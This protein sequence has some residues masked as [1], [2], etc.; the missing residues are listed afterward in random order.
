MIK[1]S[2]KGFAETLLF[3]LNI[4]LLFL[5]LFGSNMVVPQW[6]Q[7]FGRLHPVILHFPIVILIMAML[8]EFFRFRPA[9][10]DEQLYQNFTTALLL[11]GTVLAAITAIMGLFLSREPGYSG[12]ILQWHKWMG[13]SVVFVSSVI[14]WCRNSAWY[15]ELVARGGALLICVCLIFAGH[16]GADITH[17]EDFILAPVMRHDVKVPIDQALVYRDVIQPIFESK[18]ISC[19]NDDKV[20]GGL[21]LTDEASILKGGKTGKLFIPGN[22]EVSL[23][24]QRIHLPDDDEK[25]MP[26]TGKTQLSPTEMKLLYQWI[27]SKPDFNKKVMS[28]PVTDSLRILASTLLTPAAATADKYDFKAADEKTIKGLNNNYRVVYA[29]ANGSPALAVNI[30]NK[31]IYTPKVL[32]ELSPIKKQ[33]IS[34]N[35]NKMPVKDEELKT[36]AGFENLRELNLNFTDITGSGLKYLTTLKYLKSL[37]L[38]G[39]NLNANDIKQVINI[40]SLT[41]LTVWDTGIK[42]DEIQQ[43]K[44]QNKNINFIEGFKDSGKSLKLNAPQFKSKPSVF[45]KPFELLITHPI[46]GVDIRYTTDGTDPDSIKSPFYKPGIIISNNTTIKARAYK[47]GWFGSDV[48]MASYAQSLYTP[49]SIHVVAAPNS[50][51]PSTLIDKDLGTLNLDS[52]WIYA[53]KK[54]M[55]L[56]VQFLRPTPVHTIGINCM[57]IVAYQIVFPSDIEIWGG[58]DKDKLKLLSKLNIPMPKKNDPNLIKDIVCKLATDKPLAFLKIRIKPLE[59]MPSWAPP[60]STD[61][62]VYIDELFFN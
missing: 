50:F 44:K 2:H 42:D 34:L 46:K 16:F 19:H 60:K 20:K 38:A 23:I 22:P 49:D 43:L 13:A 8:F 59:K 48:V 25:H 21:M 31:T 61:A 62:D 17:G 1:S 7:P 12:H 54:E 26:P 45:S 53:V 55:I 52:K 30:Y 32:D 29:L 27:K 18:C 24:I 47:K 57:R 39:T 11:T 58:T 40:K 51:D 3:V 36:I 9:F 6:L 4:F 35:L 10:R 56:N 37:S 41:E 5:L 14:Y 28:L 33:I 15:K